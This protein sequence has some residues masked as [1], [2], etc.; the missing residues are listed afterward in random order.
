[1]KRLSFEIR[2]AIARLRHFWYETFKGGDF[3]REGYLLTVDD[4]MTRV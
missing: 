3:A 1:M 4:K 2:F